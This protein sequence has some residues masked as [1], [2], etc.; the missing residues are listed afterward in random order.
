MEETI[1][2]PSLVQT[3]QFELQAIFDNTV[4][5]IV[6]LKNRRVVHCNQ[7]AERLLGF[8]PGTLVGQSTR[9]WYV[10]D[11]DY[12]HWGKR[13]YKSLL[14]Q[15]TFTGEL[16]MRR[17]N[18]EEFWCRL[19]G[20]SQEGRLG[21]E[22]T[23]VWVLEDTTDRHHAE[24]ALLGATGLL[25]AVFNSANV[26]II[27]THPDG[28]IR[29]INTTAERW[30][31][32][33]SD[34]L[35]NQATPTI[36]HD[37][38]E[39]EAYADILSKSLGQ[40]IAPDFAVFVTHAVATG[41]DERE[42]TYIRKDGSRFPI[43]LRIS[44]LRDYR[45]EITGFVGIAID[46]TDRKR[47]D[48]ALY[49]AQMELE[50]R[51]TLRTAELAQAN[52]KLQAEI[53]ERQ[54]IEAAMR[55]MAHYDPLTSLPNRNLLQDR[56][57][58]ALALAK[59]KGNKVGILFI[60]LD[61]FK[62]INDSLGH[63]IGDLLLQQVAERMLSVVRTSD[64]LARLGGDEFLLLV[65]DP[66]TEESLGIIAEK[67][68][69]SLST[70][71]PIQTHS[72]HI[73]PSIGI[74]CFPKDGDNTDT[75]MRNAD[76]AMYHAKATGRNGYQF[77][78]HS[79]NA[80]ADQRFRI[81]SALRYAIAKDELSLHFQPLIETSTH[82][83]C[84]VEALLRWHS[85]DLGQVSPAKFI[86][87]AEDSGTI[88]S[89]GNWVLYKACRQ[90][91]EW[92]DAGLNHLTLAVNLS[93]LQFRQKDLVPMVA[94]ILEITGLPAGSLELEI[95]ESSLMNNVD[96]VIATLHKLVDLG[97]RLAVDDF[98][99]G[100]SSLAYLKHFP[101]HKLKVDQSFVRDLE[102]DQHS[103]GIVRTII[104]LAASLRLEVLAEGVETQ[105]QSQL[106]EQLGCQYMQGYLFSRPLPA[107]EVDQRLRSKQPLM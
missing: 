51:V 28:K 34:E 10:S 5:G 101:L 23:S 32:Y 98:G 16:R 9:A 87:I 85:T 100:Y 2:V 50:E 33:T 25:Q 41:A 56:M 92:H 58:Q 72:L 88:L 48:E 46:M 82:R 94:E 91:K 67:L 81:E 95:T 54:E 79:M 15:K 52:Q 44:A 83:I 38:R 14:R 22:S 21:L 4:V 103:E 80:E 57:Q 97:V 71:I 104:A 19:A 73:T 39:I 49:L 42:W 75:L 68:V 59:R 55:H 43:L 20:Q 36:L 40:T 63:D 93:P 70:P 30:L 29:M 105:N 74:C 96:E 8:A 107:T 89:I 31:G 62:T 60:D 37:Q 84:G 18:G 7:Q 12:T 1:A 45:G 99:T 65:Q 78:I 102:K 66:E 86:P 11:D 24:E 27:V 47:L 77:F 3:S 90:M 17:Q 35:I 76:T 13:V 26:S 53:A 61:R 64:T 69:A 6:L 106:L